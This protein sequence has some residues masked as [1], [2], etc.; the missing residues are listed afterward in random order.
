MKKK[1]IHVAASTILLSVLITACGGNSA[2]AA[3]TSATAETTAAIAETTA[4][5]VKE[6]GAAMGTKA[7]AK[8]AITWETIASDD[9]KVESYAISSGTWFYQGIEDE[10]SID[11]DGLKGFTAYTVEAIPETDGYLQYLGV[12]PDGYH[13]FEVYDL[14]GQYFASMIFVSEEK[15]Y[16][17]GDENEFYVKWNY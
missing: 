15:F 2:P 17:N 8:P 12:N 5:A 9:V 7:P 16:L 4:E 1:V 6:T 14:Y 13:E 10:K 3:A 11:M